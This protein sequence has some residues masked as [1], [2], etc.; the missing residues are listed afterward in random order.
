M[1]REAI[2]QGVADTELLEIVA[3][4]RR[5]IIRLPKRLSQEAAAHLRDVVATLHEADG[6][7]RISYDAASRSW[8]IAPADPAQARLEDRSPNT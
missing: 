4:D 6:W 5:L 8:D 3:R 1:R 2:D 7:F